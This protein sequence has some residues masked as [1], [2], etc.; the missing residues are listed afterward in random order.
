MQPTKEQQDFWHKDPNNWKLGM[1]YYNPE[2]TRGIVDKRIKWMG[3]TINFANKKAVIGF[4]ILM[5]FFAIVFSVL[6]TNN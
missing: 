6:T 1:F 2:D 5:L 4:L 3:I